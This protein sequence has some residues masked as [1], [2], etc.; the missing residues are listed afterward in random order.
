MAKQYYYVNQS[1]D[2]MNTRQLRKYISDKATE[3][4]KRIDSA[5]ENTSQTFKD[6]QHF[7]TDRS[8]THV[9]RDTSRLTKEEMKEMAY[10]LRE[11]NYQDF[12]SGYATEDVY[13]KNK[14]KYQQFIRDMAGSDSKEDREFWGKY[15]NEETG[16]ISKKGFQDY[17]DFVQTLVSARG[18]IEKFGYENIEQ[19]FKETKNETERTL[20]RE[21][22]KTVYDDSTGTGKSALIKAF[23]SEYEPKLAE[24]R[25]KTSGSKPKKSTKGKKPKSVSGK[26]KSSNKIKPGKPRKMK[27]HG[28]VHRS[29][30]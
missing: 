12:E 18:F 30:T 3:A 8:G 7:I 23:K 17:M 25:S 24:L 13:R 21:M 22:L 11:F 29:G 26:K 1:I 10:Q 28:T 4:Q 15:Y 2:T 19:W 5:P 9:R 6:H 14:K 16:R 20:L 27:E